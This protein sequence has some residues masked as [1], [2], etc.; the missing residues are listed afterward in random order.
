MYALF[1]EPCRTHRYRQANSDPEHPIYTI[2]NLVATF[3]TL[4]A[5]CQDVHGPKLC[6]NL[7]GMDEEGIR[8]T[9]ERVA[10]EDRARREEA[11][12]REVIVLD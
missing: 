10:I 5:H 7:A 2:S 6:D 3:E 8:E 12:T 4:K 11:A 1:I 9:R